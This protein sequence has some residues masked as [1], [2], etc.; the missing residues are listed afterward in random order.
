MSAV[1]RLDGVWH[2]AIPHAE[3]VKAGCVSGA[4][5][6]GERCYSTHTGDQNSVWRFWRGRKGEGAG[7][8]NPHRPPSYSNVSA[9]YTDVVHVC[10]TQNGSGAPPSKVQRK[11]KF[12]P[13]GSGA[14]P[15]K[16]QRTRKNTVR[17]THDVSLARMQQ[18]SV[19][20]HLAIHAGYSRPRPPP[21]SRHLPHPP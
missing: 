15:S 18:V 19:V 7:G 10:A 12:T 4:Y 8:S 6:A 9:I 1:Y 20:L 21:P 2:Y 11:R 16:V 17:N 5:T 14:P 3:T 13:N